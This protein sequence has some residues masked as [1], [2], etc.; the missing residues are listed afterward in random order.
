VGAPPW[1]RDLGCRLLLQRPPCFAVLRDPFISKPAGRLFRSQHVKYLAND[2]T[3]ITHDV[4][5]KR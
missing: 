5:M 3:M 1:T 2:V 4:A